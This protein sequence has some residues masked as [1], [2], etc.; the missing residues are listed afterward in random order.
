M[1]TNEAL[2]QRPP[3]RSTQ[4]R[5]RR[6][7]LAD[8]A[9]GCDGLVA[10]EW[11]KGTGVGIPQLLM[12]WGQGKLAEVPSGKAWDAIRMERPQGWRTVRAMR[13]VGASLGPVLHSESHVYVLVPVGSLAD[14]DQDGA[15]V[16]GR[17]EALLVPHPG[18][19]A[20][21][22]QHARSWVVPPK[23]TTLT[24]ALDLYEAYAAAGASM[25]MEGRR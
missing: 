22:T 9:S 14:W 25:A 19:V 20:P 3:T 16:L 8:A 5:I 10:L 6:A 15:S 12:T 23:G 18:I 24:D 2:P 21:C 11:I 17:G 4:D 13:T 1:T 7:A